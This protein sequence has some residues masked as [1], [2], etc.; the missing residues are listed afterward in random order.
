M[1]SAEARAAEVLTEVPRYLWNGRTLPV[2]VE[3]IADSHFKLLICETPDLATVPGAPPGPLSGLLLVGDRQI[4]VDA[5]EAAT[6]PGRRRFTIGHEL[7]HWC[8]HAGTHRKIFCRAPESP[9]GVDIEEEASLFSGALMFPPALVRR[10]W[11]TLR[12]DV[13]RMCERFGA[14][15]I[16]TE[17]AVFRVVH[18]PAVR[19]RAPSLA[20][21]AWDD[22]RYEAWRAAH[23]EDGFVCNDDLADPA[24]AKLHRAGCSYLDR[25]ARAGS[26]RTRAP[27]W[28][29]LDAGELR[30][31][32][33]EARA[34]ILCERAFRSSCA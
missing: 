15:R 4:W 11:A 3:D 5:G 33:P 2:P 7:G 6:S 20:G 1:T 9:A 16:A 26:P 24:G 27:K 22:A 30:R 29:S 25:P 23:R 19:E 14:S 34:C 17:R 10:E 13:T 32:F 21:F 12:G 28:C 31:A 18:G 8:L